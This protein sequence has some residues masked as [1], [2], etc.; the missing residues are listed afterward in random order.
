MNKKKPNIF[1]R[2]YNF[3]KAFFWWAIGGFQTVSPWVHLERYNICV[4]CPTKDFDAASGQCLD[5]GCICY[6]K[7]KWADQS[8]PKGHWKALKKS[9][10]ESEK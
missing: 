8:C 9:D 7:T 2:V 4:N 5:C 10:E 1:K 6:I 3:G